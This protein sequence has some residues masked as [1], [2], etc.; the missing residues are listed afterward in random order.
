MVR[1]SVIRTVDDSEVDPEKATW[2]GNDL[3]H[4]I[5]R[6]TARI[7]YKLLSRARDSDAIKPEGS[8]ARDSGAIKLGSKARDSGAIKPGSKARDSVQ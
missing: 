4:A 5:T 2:I 8:K 7:S 3:V 1:V 6:F